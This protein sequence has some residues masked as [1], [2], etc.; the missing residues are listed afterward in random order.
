VAAAGRDAIATLV[1]PSDVCWNEGGVPASPRPVAPPRAP[2]DAA[3]EAVA[4]VLRTGEPTVLLLGPD[5]LDDAGLR[6]A[7]RIAAATGCRPMSPMASA[8]V[9]RGAGRP[10]FDRV[11][12]PVDFALAALAG[13]RHCVLV[14]SPPPVTFFAYPGKPGTQ[15]PADCAVHVLAHPDEDGRAALQALAERVGA[16]A[17]EPPAVR[18]RPEPGRGA[19]T[20]ETLARAIA[21]RLPEQA[22]VVDE[23]VSAGRSMFGT[24]SAAAPH[25]WLQ[26]CG[27]AI[28]EGIPMATGAALGAP[29]RRVVGLQADGSALYTL[30][31]LW[32]QARM[33]LDVT[34]VIFA[35]RRYAILQGELAAVGAQPG[36]ATNAMFELQRPDL[37]WVK[38]AGGF[39]V[40]AERADTMAQFNDLFTRSMAR[41]GP[42]LIE[43]VL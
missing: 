4:R 37:D 21:A 11:P 38:L 18:P 17:F 13:T 24:L 40:E 12:Y 39:G 27:G 31:G 14:G 22:I 10:A 42:F 25:D 36:P 28:G 6:L 35:N 34:T 29:G 16:G 41:K 1:L 33:G 23:G 8:R 15:L 5:T 30:Q 3:V 19:I 32:T 43:A 9:A 2:D 20:P 26:L 7:A